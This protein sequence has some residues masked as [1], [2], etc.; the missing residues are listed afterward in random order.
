IFSNQA[1][2]LGFPDVDRDSFLY[3]LNEWYRKTGK[4]LQSVHPRDVLKTVRLI[5]E[6]AGDPVRMSPEL[7]EEACNNYF[8]KAK[9]GEIL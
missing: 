5:C 9:S 6:Y 8:V 3:L 4:P 2:A 1:Q 7:I